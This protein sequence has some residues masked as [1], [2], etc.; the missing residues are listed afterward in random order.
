M[1]QIIKTNDNEGS[2]IAAY[3]CDC[4][5]EK[6]S[7]PDYQDDDEILCQNC[8]ENS[9]QCCKKKL[10]EAQLSLNNYQNFKGRKN[11]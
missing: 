7:M 8:L 3:E 6:Q 2:Y 9:Y 4:C 11:E 5:G 10:N 1:G